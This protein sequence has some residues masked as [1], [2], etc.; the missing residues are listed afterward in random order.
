MLAVFL[1]LLS[2]F[3]LALAQQV[4]AASALC[5]FSKTR[6]S[7]LGA[8]NSR[9][10]SLSA[11]ENDR[12]KIIEDLQTLESARGGQKIRFPISE[13]DSIPLEIRARGRFEDG[14]DYSLVI[15]KT[16]G[17]YRYLV[18]RQNSDGTMDTELVTRLT[19]G[20]RGEVVGVVKT[21][22][23]QARSAVV[24]DFQPQRPPVIERF[25]NRADRVLAVEDLSGEGFLDF[26]TALRKNFASE[27]AV[28]T[29]LTG[30]N[31]RDL[32]QSGLREPGKQ[33]S[34]EKI[35]A[36]PGERSKIDSLLDR[37]AEITRNR[38][39]REQNIRANPGAVPQGR[40]RKA[41]SFETSHI[42]GPDG[43]ANLLVNKI[44]LYELLQQA[45]PTLEKVMGS[46][47]RIKEVL[48]F[49]LDL[50]DRLMQSFQ[51]AKSAE[52]KYKLLNL[53]LEASFKLPEE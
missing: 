10:V 48:D 49:N 2:S 6:P 21:P 16:T 28:R 27:T 19:G 8:E 4:T 30:Q 14:Q 13:N 20:K 44:E 26:Q 41:G 29:Q 31:L 39:L 23:V 40:A 25:E 53:F 17:E 15:D 37:A 9:S 34:Y 32:F 35:L 38:A 5:D 36:L 46:F 7:Q 33:A 22:Q 52:E 51:N 45:N 3:F 1:L 50:K 18:Q 24:V 12:S 42:D 11:E 47:P 43:V